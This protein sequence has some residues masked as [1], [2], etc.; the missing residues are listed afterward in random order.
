[1]KGQVMAK[2]KVQENKDFT[3]K[4]NNP[5][6]S[7]CMHCGAKLPG[8]NEDGSKRVRKIPEPCHACIWRNA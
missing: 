6:F 2:A 1:M 7:L 5:T 3:K 4:E 8:F